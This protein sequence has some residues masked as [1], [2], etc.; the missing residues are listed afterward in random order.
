MDALV[1]S[2][3]KNTTTPLYKLYVYFTDPDEGNFFTQAQAKAAKAR[4]W[5]P[6]WYSGNN[7]P[8]ATYEG[9]KLGDVNGDGNINSA[10]VQR[11]YSIM[12]SGATGT[13]NPEAEADLNNDG[14]INSA[15][16]Q[17]LYAIM[18]TQ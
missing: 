17:R 15:D 11:V 7:A 8:W 10:D 9:S 2:L 3:P 14:T 16:I 6:Y 13:T 4:G 12:A 18:A 1:A 5:Q